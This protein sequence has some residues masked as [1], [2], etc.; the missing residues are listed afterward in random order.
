VA[1][2]VNGDVSWDSTAGPGADL[3]SFIYEVK[4]LHLNR[5]NIITIL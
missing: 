1:A 5:T 4:Q 2:Q 3:D